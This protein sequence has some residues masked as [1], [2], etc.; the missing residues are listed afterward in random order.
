MAHVLILFQADT[1]ATEQLALA[2][3]VGAVEAEASI[4]LRRLTLPGSPELG[5]HGYGQL[6]PADLA[7][8]DTIAVLLESSRPE[9]P[10]PE[11][12]NPESLNP[13]SPNPTELT[14]LL[15][16]LRTAPP[17]T[18]PKHV[19]LLHTPTHPL[20]LLE[21]FQTA[22]FTSFDPDVDLLQAAPSRVSLT[23]GDLPNDLLAAMKQAGRRAASA[24]ATR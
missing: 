11:S 17:T 22:G 12:L 7:W 20:L 15:D 13:E 6:Q 24:T 1:E 10:N 4:R 19:T 16:L 23:A 5:H 18:T 2:V 21:A 3:A 9:S 8:A 14:P